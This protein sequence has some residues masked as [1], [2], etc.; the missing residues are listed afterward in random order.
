MQDH[1]RLSSVEILEYF[2]PGANGLAALRAGGLVVGADS[3]EGFHPRRIAALVAIE[4][5]P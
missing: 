1:H 2:A 5:A 3:N 4:L